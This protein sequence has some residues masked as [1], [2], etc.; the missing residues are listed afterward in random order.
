MQ[1]MSGAQ[2]TRAWCLD[3][4]RMSNRMPREQHMARGRPQ[5]TFRTAAADRAESIVSCCRGMSVLGDYLG[6]RQM[7][8]TEGY[9]YP[10]NNQ[11]GA[12]LN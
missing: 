1:L 11:Q 3:L 12:I 7:Q 2:E 6:V 5:T 8:H 10:I 4:S 9:R